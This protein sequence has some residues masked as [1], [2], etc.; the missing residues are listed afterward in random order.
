MCFRSLIYFLQ[1]LSCK[2]KDLAAQHS[3]ALSQRHYILSS[4]MRLIFAIKRT[5]NSTKGFIGLASK[6]SSFQ[7]FNENAVDFLVKLYASFHSKKNSKKTNFL[8]IQ[9]AAYQLLA[10][11][12]C[13][14]GVIFCTKIS[15][16]K[17]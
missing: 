2:I 12:S 17:R 7:R 1:L 4:L 15:A 11:S 6:N 10:I 3:L 9:I 14:F 16:I 5:K 13:Y 8:R